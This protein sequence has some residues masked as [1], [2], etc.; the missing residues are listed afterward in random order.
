VPLVQPDTGCTGDAFQD[1]R[2]LAQILAGVTDKGFLHFRV[3]ID[4]RLLYEVRQQLNPGGR[5][6]GAM[7]V[8]IGMPG[9]DDGVGHGLAAM[10]AHGLVAAI[11]PGGEVQAPGHRQAAMKTG[12]PVMAA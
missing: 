2:R 12:W 6:R 5:G 1:Q 7:P 3:I 8:E 9:R 10:A 4:A 11:D